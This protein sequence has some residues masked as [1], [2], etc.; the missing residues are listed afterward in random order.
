MFGSYAQHN[1]SLRSD[2]DIL[3]VLKKDKRKMTDRLDEFILEFSNGPVPV[4]VLVYTR[5]EIETALKE[6]NRFLTDASAGIK[7]L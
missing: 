6:G 3:V 5:P 2:A 4:D 1:A 7:L